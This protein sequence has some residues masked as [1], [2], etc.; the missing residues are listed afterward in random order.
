MFIQPYIKWVIK[1]PSNMN[2]AGY[3]PGYLP[4]IYPDIPNG[5]GPRFGWGDLSYFPDGESIRNEESGFV[6]T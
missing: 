6:Q 3:I 2:I 1:S 4:T 5:L